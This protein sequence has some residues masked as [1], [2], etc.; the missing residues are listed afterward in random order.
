MTFRKAIK[1]LG[2]NKTL[3]A[4]KAVIYGVTTFIEIIK[5]IMEKLLKNDTNRFEELVNESDYKVKAHHF[6]RFIDKISSKG[7]VLATIFASSPDIII[8]DPA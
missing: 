5:L 7:I 8:L 2:D 4:R 1:H 3:S 6:L